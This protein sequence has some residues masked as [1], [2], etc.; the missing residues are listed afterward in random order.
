MTMRAEFCGVMR[1]SA[2]GSRIG[3]LVTGR[4]PSCRAGHAIPLPIE[5]ASL[6]QTL[7][8]SLSPTEGGPEPVHCAGHGPAGDASRTRALRGLA[9]RLS[10]AQPFDPACVGDAGWGEFACSAKLGSWRQLSDG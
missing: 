1:W 8:A 9:S 3:A 7:V 5:A 2:S 6:R 10:R 4:S